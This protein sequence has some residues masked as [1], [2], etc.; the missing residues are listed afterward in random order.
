VV[1]V[2]VCVCLCMY[3]YVC[4]SVYACVQ[5]IFTH[6]ARVLASVLMSCA[7][8]D[9]RNELMSPSSQEHRLAA[10]IAHNRH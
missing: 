6:L 2:C 4:V 1:C 7:Q 5:D 10:V 3:V 9:L 8:E